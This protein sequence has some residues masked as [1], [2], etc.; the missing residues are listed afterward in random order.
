[1]DDAH[2]KRSKKSNDLP[3]QMAEERREVEVLKC[4]VGLGGPSREGGEEG[5]RQ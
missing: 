4:R 2:A 3:V 1:M 5:V